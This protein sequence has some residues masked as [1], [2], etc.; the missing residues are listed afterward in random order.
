MKVL[1]ATDGS[2]DARCAEELLRAVGNR[3]TVDLTVL[4]VSAGGSHAAEA[5]LFGADAAAD[6][7]GRAERIAAGTA[8]RLEADG[9]TV[10]GLVDRGPAGPR[11]VEAVRAGGYGLVVVGSGRHSA[12][13]RVLMGSVSFHVL[14][15]APSSVL[16]VHDPPEGSPPWKVLVATDGSEDAEEAMGTFVGFAEPDRCRVTV[17]SVAAIPAYALM[18]IPF[19]PA[20]AK[21]ATGWTAPLVGEADRVA[22]G[23]AA[24]LR[25]HGFHCDS[26]AID[27]AVQ[28]AILGECDEGQ[29]R[30]VVAGSRGLGPLGRAVLGSVSDAIVRHAPAALIGRQVH[31]AT[32]V[33]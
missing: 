5:L 4:S 6:L 14:H 13:A 22:E 28:R 18:P 30:L 15:S 27:G 17:M 25:G 2:D 9:F 24:A 1:F 3:R 29:H 31:H 19:V 11:I 16:V 23:A 8:S 32:V 20:G 26:V 33:R 7:E 21:E 10:A 12:L